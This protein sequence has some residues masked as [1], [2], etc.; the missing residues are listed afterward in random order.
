MNLVVCVEQDLDTRVPFRI[1]PDGVVS[2]TEPAPIL[3][4]NAGDR[5][6]LE[7]ALEL[8]DA[9]R[10][11]TVT[12]LTLAPPGGHGALRLCLARGV[13]R[14]VHVHDEGLPTLDGYAA[15][16]V[17]SRAIRKMGSA[18]VFCGHNGRA[19]QVGPMLA[20]LLGLP[21][22]TGVVQFV[23]ASSETIEVERRLEK[24]NRER[25]VCPLPALLTI[26]SSARGARYVSIRAGLAALGREVQH[27]PLRSLLNDDE[28]PESLACTRVIRVAP[29]RPRPKKIFTPDSSLSAED[30]LELVVSGG[31]GSKKGD[32]A[33]GNPR[34]L[35][36]RI[37][38]FLR[39]QKLIGS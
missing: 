18:L 7:L 14:A 22:V 27:I 12:A 31:L 28:S 19:S 25:V 39:D 8:R 2:Q 10:V 4:L 34:E 30:R 5:A 20:E 24:G 26:D 21:Q 38:K 13:D 6:A 9:G 11:R 29:P 35:A 36:A 15:A 16:C 32:L 23:L 37:A 3:S 33:E 1:T 17:L